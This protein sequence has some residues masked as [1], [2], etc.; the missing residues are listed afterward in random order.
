MNWLLQRIISFCSVIWLHITKE[1]LWK[2]NGFWSSGINA[3]FGTNIHTCPIIT[4]R[5]C[6]HLCCVFALFEPAAGASVTWCSTCGLP[7]DPAPENTDMLQ[8]QPGPGL[9]PADRRGRTNP[10]TSKTSCCLKSIEREKWIKWKH[11][12]ALQYMKHCMIHMEIWRY[13][14]SFLTVQ[15]ILSVIF[16][17]LCSMCVWS[18][19]KMKQPSLQ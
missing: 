5:C 16:T 12:C 6:R 10:E 19:M 17:L 11:T 4:R 1:T 8:N 2:D 15:Q 7:E 9:R 13:R 3:W 14:Q 18:T